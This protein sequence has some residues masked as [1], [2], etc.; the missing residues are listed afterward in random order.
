MA[1]AWA[2]GYVLGAASLVLAACCLYQWH[3]SRRLRRS[4]S[5]QLGMPGERAE[6]K[7]LR[8]LSQN[9]WNVQWP[10]TLLK[11]NSGR[12]PMERFDALVAAA[13]EGDYDVLALQ[14][15][16]VLR[17]GPFVFG[18]EVLY[19]QR[20]LVE[21]GYVYHTDIAYNLPG[22]FG[23][24]A[25]VAV[26]S[27]LPIPNDGVRYFSF[28]DSSWKEMPNHKGFVH[29]QLAVFPP[30]ADAASLAD[31]RPAH[32]LT[33]HLDSSADSNIRISQVKTISL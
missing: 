26:F 16:F 24:S 6:R 18:E 20:R 12:Y 30:G 8:V 5:E 31:Q 13:V 9:M 33:A 25:G 27:R 19:L 3:R 29:V 10:G 14:E 21:V 32:I 15:L 23:Q 1:G 2:S 11:G 7:E 22:V 17:V 28:A 4:L